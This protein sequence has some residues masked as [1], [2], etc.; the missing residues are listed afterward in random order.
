MVHRVH[1]A[2]HG[3]H[4]LLRPA[5]GVADPV[6]FPLRVGVLLSGAVER[7][8][9]HPRPPALFALRKNPPAARR[10]LD[11]QGFDRLVT[12]HM[13]VIGHV[14]ERRMGGHGRTGG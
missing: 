4:H 9:L 11:A 12:V 8:H 1:R 7:H 5:D 10:M 13:Q 14:E 2:V 6:E 3:D